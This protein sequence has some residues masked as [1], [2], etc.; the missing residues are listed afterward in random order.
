M[1]GINSPTIRDRLLRVAHRLLGSREEAEDV[2]QEVL[3]KLC[4]RSDID[5]LQ[6]VEAYAVTMAKNLCFDIKRKLDRVRMVDLEKAIQKPEYQTPETSFEGRESYNLIRQTM[7]ELNDSYKMVVHL[8]DIEEMEY[9]EIS[10]IM[11]MS[12]NQVR[13]TLSRARKKLREALLNDKKLEYETSRR[14]AE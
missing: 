4:Q 12:E 2:A 11:Q 8:R 7:E 6:N 3:L 13:V 10:G 1:P 14:A 5:T 9:A